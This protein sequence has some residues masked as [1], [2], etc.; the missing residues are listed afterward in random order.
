MSYQI[1]K[2]GRHDDYKFIDGAIAD[3]YNMGGVDMWLYTYLGP[4]TSGNNNTSG[5]QVNNSIT[6]IG[7]LVFGEAAS[8]SYSLQ[9]IT[10]P[11]VYQIQE[12]TPD[13]KIP[14]LFFNFD[15]MDITI[16]YNTMM[17]RVGRKIMPGDVLEL[18]N[19]RDFDV[20]NKDSGFNRF[21]VVQDSFRTAEGYSVTW[22][23]H[24]FKL[25]VKPLTDSPEFSGIIGDNDYPVNP[26]D[27]NSG[28][29]NNSGGGNTNSTQNNEI[30]IMNRLIAQADD[31]V[32]Y[33]HW[34]NEHIYNDIDGIN[35][36]ARDILSGY[37]FPV[38]PS[39]AMF[40]N[41]L[42]Y[43]VLYERDANAWAI[44]QAQYGDRLPSKA[45]D[46]DFFFKSNKADVS[47]Y[48]LFQY[49]A[50]S[51]R[52][53]EC[54]LPYTEINAVPVGVDDF[55][56]YYKEPQLYQVQEDKTTWVI[57]EPSESTHPFTSKGIAAN[58][59]NPQDMRP[60]IPPARGT[61]GEGTAFPSNPTNKEYFY[62]TDLTPVTLWRYNAET[63][64]WSQFNY[65]GRLP[66]VGPNQD[67]ARFVNGEDRVALSDVVKP[68]IAYRIKKDKK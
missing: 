14:G 24:I 4:A 55:Y 32:P 35:E 5:E 64:A 27:P 67:Q 22:Q 18:P 45:S 59:T 40:F 41:K 34:D 2:K 53:I 66:W 17:Q 21:Y 39:E 16:H 47:G 10:L 31:E 48:S 51:K 25:R 63:S 65:G 15:T 36:L 46:G 44:V 20:L 26:D 19:L 23:H 60:E 61:V 13:L 58:R 62:R 68:N 11:V 57:P 54:S 3:Q 37:E 50:S 29:G 6:E 9:A 49:Y 12:A 33:I 7:D 42:S 56:V 1:W 28:N 8:R 43:P 30:D 52:W 38:N